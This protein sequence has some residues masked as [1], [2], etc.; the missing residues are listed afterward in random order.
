MELPK[1]MVGYIWRNK[2][3]TEKAHIVMYGDG[4]QE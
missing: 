4:I 3:G 2:S 1:Q